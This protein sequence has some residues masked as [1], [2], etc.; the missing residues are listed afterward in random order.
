MLFS[1]TSRYR[2]RVTSPLFASVHLEINMFPLSFPAGRSA[3][4]RFLQV[5]RRS[6]R[7]VNMEQIPGYRYVTSCDVPFAR[8]VNF[9]AG[10]EKFRAR[11]VAAVFLAK[12]FIITVIGNES[13]AKDNWDKPTNSPPSPSLCL[14]FLFFFFFYSSSAPINNSG[15]EIKD[16][17]SISRRD[18]TGRLTSLL[19]TELLLFVRLS[20][21]LS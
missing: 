16:R 14:P 12:Q 13:D 1:P 8:I 4:Q 19:I 3:E 2:F 6:R 17:R 18:Y 20:P 21:R 15:K 9:A 5:P 10:A 7:D 11:T